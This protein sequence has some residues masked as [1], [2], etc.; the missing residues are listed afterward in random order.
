MKK[1]FLVMVVVFFGLFT[2]S[3]TIYEVTN[4]STELD[5]KPH[6]VYYLPKNEISIGLIIKTEAIIN[7]YFSNLDSTRIDEA[8]KNSFVNPKD[9]YSAKPV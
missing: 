1:H 3:C 5:G 2:S 7:P 9:Y 6:I 4:K 8:L